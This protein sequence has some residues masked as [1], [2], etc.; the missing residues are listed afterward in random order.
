MTRGQIEARG[1]RLAMRHGV[2]RASS[3]LMSTTAPSFCTSRFLLVRRP[4]TSPA[5]STVSRPP[6]ACHRP[7]RY[8]PRL[9]LPASGSKRLEA[10]ADRLF[11]EMV[12][13]QEELDW[14]CLHLYGLT[15][16]PLTVPAG[17]TAP[18]LELGERAF[19]IVL[20]RKVTAGE[21]ETAW[22]TRH[23]STPITELPM[24]WPGW[25]RDLVQQTDRPDRA[26]SGRGS[27]GAARAQAAVGSGA[28]GEAGGGRIAGVAGSIVW[29]T[30]G[31]GSRAPATR[32]GP[33]AAASPNWL[34]GS[35]P[36]TPSSSMWPGCGRARSRSTR[37]R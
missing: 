5:S 11:A 17:E 22:F 29:R 23:R 10:I 18:P 36:S 24:H 1:L 31:S 32:S 34:I 33:F 20:A 26:G 37:W 4:S 3:T 27:G 14:T 6:L 9:R 28:V 12:A 21:T 15:D 8:P 7:R 30:G 35:E 16:A 2:T 25:Y 19:E 13:A